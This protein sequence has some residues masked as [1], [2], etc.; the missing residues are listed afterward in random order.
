MLNLFLLIQLV[1]HPKPFLSA[2]DVINIDYKCTFYGVAWGAIGKAYEI[3][4][5]MEFVR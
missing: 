4:P 2:K 5:L 1:S 3:S